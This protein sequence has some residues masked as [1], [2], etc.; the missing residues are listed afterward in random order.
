MVP[1]GTQGCLFD[2]VFLGI[3]DWQQSQCESH[4]CKGQASEQE[5]DR[6]IKNER[7]ELGPGRWA[8]EQLYRRPE[9][10]ISFASLPCLGSHSFS[11]VYRTGQWDD[12][13]LTRRTERRETQQCVITRFTQEESTGGLHSKPLFIVNCKARWGC[14]EHLRELSF[15]SLPGNLCQCWTALGRK[16][17]FCLTYFTKFMV[18]YDYS[19]YDFT[20]SENMM[21]G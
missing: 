11:L 12:P 7:S 16:E 2:S 17:R 5:E 6:Q 4:L 18:K 15:P 8:Q 13:A 21:Y 20:K 10:P 14:H 9:T 19:S 3:H 1:K